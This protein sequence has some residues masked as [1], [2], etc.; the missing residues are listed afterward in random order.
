MKP[1]TTY[2]RV[3][4]MIVGYNIPKSSSQTSRKPPIRLSVLY[5]DTVITLE[6]WPHTFLPRLTNLLGAF[7]AD[8]IGAV[9]EYVGQQIEFLSSNPP[10]QLF[11]DK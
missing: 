4:G 1:T 7:A 8:V 10:V 11:G 3:S 5:N 9:K 2:V 6:V